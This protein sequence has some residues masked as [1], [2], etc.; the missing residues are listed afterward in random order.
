MGQV[1]LEWSVAGIAA[2]PPAS[3]NAQLAQAMA[4][5]AASGSAVVT[6]STDQTATQLP[7]PTILTV[8]NS[9]NLLP[10]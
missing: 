10:G 2:D 7:V 3:V 6:P 9:Q 5:Y 8:A 4:S 1:G